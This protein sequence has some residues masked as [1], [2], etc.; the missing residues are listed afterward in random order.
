MISNKKRFQDTTSVF[1]LLMTF[2]MFEFICTYMIIIYNIILCSVS[3]H[4]H[5]IIYF[6]RPVG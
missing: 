6:T 4:F 5:I 2:L 1:R 3:I